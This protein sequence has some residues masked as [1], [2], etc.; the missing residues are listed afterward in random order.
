MRKYVRATPERK[1]DDAWWSKAQ[2]PEQDALP[3]V[4][5][6]KSTKENQKG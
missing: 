2:G 1:E 6:A 5:Y 3:F 4:S